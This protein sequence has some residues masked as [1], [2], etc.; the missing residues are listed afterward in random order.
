MEA[1]PSHQWKSGQ[2]LPNRLGGGLGAP[3][4]LVDLWNGLTLVLNISVFEPN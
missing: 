1:G 2:H 4:L 3:S